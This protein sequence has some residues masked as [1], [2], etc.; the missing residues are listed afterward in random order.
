MRGGY[1][2]CGDNRIAKTDHCIS[3]VLI[4]TTRKEQKKMRFFYIEPEVAGGLG[5][6]TILDPSTHPPRI[7]HLHYEF[8][9]WLGDA[10]LESFPCVI[11]TQEAS[12][13]LIAASITG[14]ESEQMEVSSTDEFQQLYPQRR[15]PAFRWLKVNGVAGEDDF[16]VTADL[17]IVVSEKVINILEPLGLDNALIENLE[18]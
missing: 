9:G 18:D 11:A 6:N 5:A 10:L 13:A 15:L 14:V 1:P 16:G 12:D 17:R 2:E 3:Y 7:D 4:W 8:Y